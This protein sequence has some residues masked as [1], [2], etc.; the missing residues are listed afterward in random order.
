[1]AEQKEISTLERLLEVC[2]ISRKGF[3]DAAE[4]TKDPVLQ[5]RF[6]QFAQQRSL[7]VET[8]TDLLKQYGG[9]PREAE[10]FEGNMMR[11]WIDFKSGLI[12]H[13]NRKIIE[14]CLK[15]EKSTLVEF[16]HAAN[17]ELE[18]QIKE[19]IFSMDVEV[20][21]AYQ[22]LQHLEQQYS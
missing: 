12:G 4:Q 15:E 19:K 3:A 14:Q 2:R 5:S 8:L 18:D 22:Q 17:E 20:K 21:E 1:M 16:E 11:M 7:Y 9:K 6:N 13:D 10:S